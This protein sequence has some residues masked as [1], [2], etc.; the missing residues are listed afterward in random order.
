[1]PRRKKNRSDT[2]IQILYTVP[3]S[4][5]FFRNFHYDQVGR[6][7][8]SVPE[9]NERLAELQRQAAI[10]RER[11]NSEEDNFSSSDEHEPTSELEY[12]HRNKDAFK[13]GKYVWCYCRKLRNRKILC[14]PYK[15]GT[16]KMLLKLTEP[17]AEVQV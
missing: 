6:W 10:H 12:F 5:H 8:S 7:V 15:K 16:V 2:S 11:A 3:E 17:I 9:E 14:L 4:N 13:S 1:M